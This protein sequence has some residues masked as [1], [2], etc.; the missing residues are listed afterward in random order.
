M[1]WCW[2]CSLAKPDH[3]DQAKETL[4]KEHA[5]R[6][7]FNCKSL[8][9]KIEKEIAT[10]KRGKIRIIAHATRNELCDKNAK[11]REKF[12]DNINFT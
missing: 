11:S 7:S 5:K 10:R 1:C 3:L 6:M 9:K 12:N 8:V 4:H 2:C